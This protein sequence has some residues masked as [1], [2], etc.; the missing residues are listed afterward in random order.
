MVLEV[1][2]DS[3]DESI[4]SIEAARYLNIP[5]D[6][7]IALQLAISTIPYTIVNGQKMYKLSNLKTYML[8]KTIEK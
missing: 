3:L 6:K 8:N 1:Q 5:E 2:E 7:F 4:N